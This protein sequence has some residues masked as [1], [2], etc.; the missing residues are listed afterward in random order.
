MKWLGAILGLLVAAFAALY[1]L[2][3]T[4]PGNSIVAPIVEDKINEAVP[5][6][7]SL[8]KFELTADTFAITL[9]LSENNRIEAVGN[10]SLFSRSLN[11]AYRVRA[12]DLSELEPLS[13]APLKGKLHT[14]GKVT[15]TL[16]KLNINGTSDLAGSNTEYAVELTEFD[17]TS[18]T[19]KVSE[20]ELALL[21]QMAGQK[22]YSSAKVSLDA[23]L[24][25]I[26]PEA[27]DGE[28]LLNVVQGRMNKAV[29][30]QDFNLTLPDT[31]YTAT[32]NARLNG[33]Q[34]TYDAKLD[35]TLAYLFS[36]GKVT[37]DPLSTDLH[38]EVNVKEL[39]LFKPLTNAPL[40]G[41]FT[42]SG[43]VKGDRERMNIIG[44]SDIAASKTTY[45]VS[46][47]AFKAQR[48][49]AKVSGAKLAKLLYMAG[50]PAYAT[51]NLDIDLSLKSLD[52]ENLLGHADVKVS[53][54]KL[55]SGV[56]K[57]TYKI[58][59]P[60]KTSFSYDL[61]AKLNGTQVD[62]TTL[63]KSNLASIDSKGSV[64]PKTLGMDLGYTVNVKKLEL[65]KPLTNAPLRG[66][67]STSGTVKGDEKRLNILGKSDIAA[68]K[69]TYDVTMEELKAQR[70]LAKVSGA[71]LARLLHLAGQPR[72]A[73]GRLDA[74]VSLESLDFDNLK[75]MADVKITKGSLVPNAFKKSFDITI[76]KTSFSYDL[77]TKLNGTQVDYTTLLSSNL[78]K[79]DSKG[80]V[81][82]KTLGMDLSYRL[83]IKKLELL[84]PL[85]DMPLRGALSLNGTAKGDE[86]LLTVSGN[87]NL[88]ES[89]TT[90]TAQLSEFSPQSIKADIKGAQ[91]GKL[92]YMIEQP[93]YADARLDISADIGNARPGELKGTV[94]S[95]LSKGVVNGK[96]VSKAFEFQPMPR[97]TF[98]GKTVTMLKG[99]LV[100]TKADISS[101]LAKLNVKKARYD[102]DKA[103]LTSDYKAHI[104]DLDKLF[105][106]T[107]RHLKG[108]L[109]V[110]GTLKKGEAFDLSAHSKTLGGTLNAT[111]HNDDVHAEFKK[112][113]TLD[114]LEM[115][116]YPQ[117]FKSSL[118][119]TFDYNLKKGAGL[120]D[121]KLSDGTFTNNV[122]LDLLKEMAKVDLYRENFT[123][124]AS[125]SINKEKIVADLDMRSRKSSVSGNRIR[126][127]T[128]TQKIDANLKV[129]ANNNP[130]GVKLTG[131]V[132]KPKVKLDVKELLE[133]EAKKALKKEGQKALEKE[134]NKLLHKLF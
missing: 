85:T 90:F 81:T 20:A 84:K 65:L 92:L 4:P 49:L 22:P 86:K 83:D 89:K 63:L 82:P 30:K 8:E 123:S 33:K 25:S 87:S 133:K 119:G 72:Y 73:T 88:A 48:V 52:P 1:V 17:P 40:R 31:T 13:Q 74:D 66:P 7:T 35:S 70:V 120:F 132:N 28:L 19:A 77:E 115:L 108:G 61:D 10:Y 41:P 131:N 94:T 55:V 93:H 67:F 80:S 110:T 95:V 21:L 121:A 113:Q 122:M 16:E 34:I 50:E 54:G 118:D 32:A 109:T 134:V 71:D 47:E 117:V 107:E 42:T 76:P 68:S 75:G 36:Q 6:K 100:D 15:G 37:P 51:G 103:L 43:T 105:F 14:E 27:M 129:V 116:L 29:M 112:I 98:S 124:T 101:S 78:A 18:I 102:L 38:Y 45:D 99:N 11:A 64:I 91:L 125:G 96:V 23:N 126:L 44:K 127:N 106:V 2:L 79:L 9:L 24:K 69:T 111:V 53:Q 97:T 59:L 57:E 46:L 26:K 104:P 60:P 128:K 3:F 12:N 39:A 56:F 114:A 58:T 62:Y 130:V 5:L